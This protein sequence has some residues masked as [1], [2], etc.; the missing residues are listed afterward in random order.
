MERG[1]W[2]HIALWISWYLEHEHKK[3]DLEARDL[4]MKNTGICQTL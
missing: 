3:H 4:D 2:N 1:D